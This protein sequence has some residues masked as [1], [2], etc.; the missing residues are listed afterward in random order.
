[1]KYRWIAL[2]VTLLLLAA[3]PA[4]AEGRLP[5][6][7]GMEEVIRLYNDQLVQS[8]L[9]I[10]PT[11]TAT[12]VARY[13]TSGI[14]PEG[15]V[16]WFSNQDGKVEISAYFPDGDLSMSEPPATLGFTYANGVDL[17]DIPV[18]KN[19]FANV[20][21]RADN[22][23]DLNAVLDWMNGATKG[24][25]VLHMNGYVLLHV[26]NDAGHIY[27]LAVET[28]TGGGEP[29]PQPE[30]EPAPKPESDPIPGPMS[31]SGPD[32]IDA[33]EP[34]PTH[35]PRVEAG[36]LL[37]WKGFE[38]TPL[39]TE[40][41]QFSS[42]QLSLRLYL[43]VVNGAKSEMSLRAEDVTVDGVSLPD[44]GIYDIRSGTDTGADSE[45]N[46]LIYPEDNTDRIKK[47]V[48]YGKKMSMKLV[49]RDNSAREDVYM[50]KVTLDLSELPNETTIY[51]PSSDPT[52]T[53]RATRKPEATRAPSKTTYKPLF[54]GDKGEDVRRMQRKLIELGYLTDS[55]D[56][57]FGP[58]TAAA[59]RE[60]CETNG[61]G[62][63]S[64]ASAAML[65][66]L[67]SGN[68]KPYQ[69]P[70]VPL[71]FLDD[72]RG[73]WKNASGDKLSFRAKV[74]NT[75]RTHTVRAFEFYMYAIDVWG[76]KIYG[77]TIYYGTTTR[78]VKPG[79]SAFSDYFVLPNR[80]KISKVWC[81]V[82]K[83]IFSDGTVRENNTVDYGYWTIK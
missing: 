7:F 25:E 2:I 78:T 14:S 68:A 22:T 79:Q 47:A 42:G 31:D 57:S 45:A 74:T 51:E 9:A 19:V 76:D 59:V 26:R 54:Q 10:K 36:T 3:L 13:K 60:F 29:T 43:R 69:E 50:E 81:G 39:R 52:P 37:S 32:I 75:S 41:W 72:A 83:V 4:S 16:F 80:S 33:P 77:D 18:L 38:L 53:P 63:D 65:E 6:C 56:G 67:Y 17:L 23:A 82:K 73:Q 70:W 11:E 20:I 61:L 49:L 35:T 5:D 28:E 15:N 8:F 1:M 64:Y 21:A 12:K 62:S 58:R 27:S 71:I 40:R 46:I 30:S 24:S 55:A 34:E 44:G 48:L 66:K